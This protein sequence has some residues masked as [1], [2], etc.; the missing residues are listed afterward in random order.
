[1]GC[2]LVTP[3]KRN[4][5]GRIT[6][7]RQLQHARAG[8]TH[9]PKIEFTRIMVIVPPSK[10]VLNTY[11]RQMDNRLNKE[12]TEAFPRTTTIYDKLDYSVSLKLS[13]LLDVPGELVRIVEL[14]MKQ[15]VYKGPFKRYE[16]ECI[17]PLKEWTDCR[18]VALITDYYMNVW[19]W[20]YHRPDVTS[21][22]K[23]HGIAFNKLD[24]A[25]FNKDNY[26]NYLNNFI[27]ALRSNWVRASVDDIKMMFCGNNTD[28]DGK[29]CVSLVN[30]KLG[31]FP[32]ADLIIGFLGDKI[33][34]ERRL[35]KCSCN[36]KTKKG[37]TG[38]PHKIWIQI[39]ITDFDVVNKF[40]AFNIVK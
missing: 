8:C 13:T 29:E 40:F 24:E 16:N 12:Q 37:Y 9:A 5:R 19:S 23:S 34:H 4:G 39:N 30:Y 1:M 33:D 25:R 32:Y 20:D 35:L 28:L 17:L 31:E 7:K 15:P 22:Q 21:I 10:P 6:K 36:W 26:C 2:K 11:P 27:D 38:D 14:L 18:I 3:P